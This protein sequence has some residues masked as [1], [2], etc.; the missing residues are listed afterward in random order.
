MVADPG[1]ESVSAHDWVHPEGNVIDPGCE[2]VHVSG[3]LLSTRPLSVL[4]RE[5]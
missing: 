1:F 5:L 2:D 4:G 3:I